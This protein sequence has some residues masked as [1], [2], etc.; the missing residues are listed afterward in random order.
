MKLIDCLKMAFSDLNK[1]KL[2][3][4]LTSL[5]IAVGTLLVI[6]MAGLGQGIQKISADQIKQMDTFRIITVKPQ[7]KA[8]KDQAKHKTIDKEM[9][10]KFK[11]I[12][13]VSTITA[14]INTTVTEAKIGD[15]VG[16][17]IQI[18]GNDLDYTIFTD[19]KKNEIKSDKEKVKKYGYEP[20]IAGSIIK[21][22]D[23]D[24][25]LV[26][27]GYLNKI[28]IKDYKSVIGKNIEMK[29]SLPNVPGIMQK[30]PIVINAK[31]A[32][33]V[34]RNYETGKNVITTPDYMAAKIQE[35]YM[36]ETDYMK[37]KGYDNVSVEAKTMQDVSKIDSEISKN[38]YVSQ[39]EAGYA[40]R[41]NTMLT[42][43][44][45][46]LIAAGAIVLLVASI[47]VI[48]TMT[49]SVY[50]KTKSI[51]IMKAE[52]ASR[53][54]I[55]RIFVVQSGSLGFIGGAVG[56]IIA[57]IAAIIINK[58]MVMYKIGG[59][60]SGMKIIDVR[61]SIIVYTLLFTVLVAIIAGIVPSRKA[62]KLNPVDSLR[63]E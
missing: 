25:V 58:V 12:N 10:N 9:L 60:E 45:A 22:G 4:T 54:N 30:Q 53:K 34:N 27:A 23:K 46:L 1:R 24:S 32:G 26:G 29:V 37:N 48:N 8:S 7:D 61:I 6:L 42:I 11:N 62:A 41:M 57:L 2:R 13:K 50:E 47:G 56:S 63:S 51:G 55:R 38:G 35:Y 40:D 31:I 39:S 49:M 28:G 19:A 14:S 36:N 15:K 59:I 3:T 21:Q 33:V 43:V 52:G 17:N 5:G 16:K 20:I 44:K 18:Q